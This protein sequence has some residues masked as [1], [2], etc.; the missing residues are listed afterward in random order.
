MHNKIA[1]QNIAMNCCTNNS[2]YNC[3][4]L[5]KNHKSIFLF[6]KLWV[7]GELYQF[8]GPTFQINKYI[9]LCKLRTFY[10]FMRLNLMLWWLGLY[11]SY[12]IQCFSL[13][14]LGS[15]HTSQII[16]SLFTVSRGVCRAISPR[17][18]NHFWDDK[19]MESET[20]VLMSS[21]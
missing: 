18:H 1:K 12:V 19:V 11:D 14:W 4:D 21:D 6:G 7:A 2:D 13:T 15:N 16:A 10:L 20:I 17:K 8:F 5:E 9:M 3:Y